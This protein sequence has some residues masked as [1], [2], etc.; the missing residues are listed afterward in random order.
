MVVVAL[1]CKHGLRCVLVLRWIQQALNGGDEGGGGGG[2][3][4]MLQ[5][6][7]LS[8]SFPREE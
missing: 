1:E 3:G 2:G 4:V 8:L 5:A 6:P 7:P